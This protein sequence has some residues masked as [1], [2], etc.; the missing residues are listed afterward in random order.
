MVLTTPAKRAKTKNGAACITKSTIFKKTSMA[1]SIKSITGLDFSLG[2]NKRHTP[3]KIPKKIICN[4][5]E[6]LLK[7]KKKFSGTISTKG[8][9]GDWVVFSVTAFAD[10]ILSFSEAC[11][12]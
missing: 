1:L 7:E 11:T 6:L 9:K 4:I 12:R 10:W 8:C 2:I 5:K 3:K